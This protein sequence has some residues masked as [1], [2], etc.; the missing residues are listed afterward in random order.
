MLARDCLRQEIGSLQIHLQHLFEALLGGF[1]EIR[2]RLRGA[3]GVV[4]QRM[5]GADARLHPIDQPCAI[6]GAREIGRHVGD[7]AP[8]LA[9]LAQHAADRAPLAHSG[10][11]EVPSVPSERLRDAETDAARPA[12]DERGAGKSCGHASGGPKNARYLPCPASR[13]T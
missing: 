13:F 8:V 3:A 1:E 7:A 12:G 11:H 9:Q 10:D 6:G 4:H 5:N 2:P